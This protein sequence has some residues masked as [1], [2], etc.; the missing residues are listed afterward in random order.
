MSL[1]DEHEDLSQEQKS[2]VLGMA[3]MD[4]GQVSPDDFAVLM[5]QV[6]YLLKDD[7]ITLL[8]KS[9]RNMR[10]LMPALSPLLRTTRI[11]DRKVL[12]LL[13]ARWKLAVR[14]ELFINADQPAT[15]GEFFAWVNFGEAAIEDTYKGWRGNLVTVRQRTFRM[16]GGTKKPSFLNRLLGRG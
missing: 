16:E 8:L 6:H 1:G 11:N 14:V 3:S 15:M 5:A 10:R 4:S 7:D 2:E 9:N 12:R 13:K